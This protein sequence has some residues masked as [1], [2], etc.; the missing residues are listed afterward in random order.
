M[1]THAV[2]LAIAIMMPM[3]ETN[4]AQFSQDDDR[5]EM[6]EKDENND[7]KGVLESENNDGKEDVEEYIFYDQSGFDDAASRQLEYFARIRELTNIN[8]DVLTPPPEF[9]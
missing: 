8:S 6:V 4:L 1:Q 3:L 2:I 5:Y 9:A 7:Q